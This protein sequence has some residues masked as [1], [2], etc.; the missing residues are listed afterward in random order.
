MF[1]MALSLMIAEIVSESI[2]AGT[3]LI[4]NVRTEGLLLVELQG[5]FNIFEIFTF[6]IDLH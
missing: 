5:N 3:N 2:E 6:W 1:W 4:E